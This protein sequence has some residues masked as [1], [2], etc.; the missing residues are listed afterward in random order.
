MKWVCPKGYPHDCCRFQSPS[1]T[2]I[3][4]PREQ[5]CP[6]LAVVL[7]GSPGEFVLIAE[8]LARLPEGLAEGVD[9]DAGFGCGRRV[10]QAEGGGVKGLGKGGGVLVVD[11]PAGAD[12]VLNAAREEGFRESHL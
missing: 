5:P 6:G 10:G 4:F 8:R 7:V 9:V 11:G 3:V 12:V 1:L 2:R